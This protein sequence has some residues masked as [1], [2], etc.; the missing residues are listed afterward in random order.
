[1]LLMFG[2]LL[3]RDD[4]TAP[5]A[6]STATPTVTPAVS[7]TPTPIAF[8]DPDGIVDGG[9]PE[10]SVA[11]PV[12]LHITLANENLPGVWVVQRRTVRPCRPGPAAIPLSLLEPMGHGALLADALDVPFFQP[13]PQQ[14]KLN[15]LD[16]MY[17]DLTEQILR[18]Q[19]H[20]VRERLCGP[21]WQPRDCQAARKH[22]HVRCM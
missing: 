14:T 9:D 22:Q 7:V 13:A 18:A 21:Q 12:S 19:P 1:M 15:P 5:P 4:G 16:V 11:Y 2:F 3:L 17:P 8:N 6:E 10:R 20:S